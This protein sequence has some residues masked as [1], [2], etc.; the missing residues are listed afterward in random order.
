MPDIAWDGLVKC[1]GVLCTVLV[2]E[3]IRT[4]AS[5]VNVC[6]KWSG[7]GNE[8]QGEYEGH[9]ESMQIQWKVPALNSSHLHHR[10]HHIP[11]HSALDIKHKLVLTLTVTLTIT[12]PSLSP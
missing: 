2:H 5:L 1:F 12:S 6:P 10:Q 9:G 7:R 4:R 11:S 8:S 3:W